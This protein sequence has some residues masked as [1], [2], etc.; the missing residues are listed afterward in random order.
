MVHIAFFNLIHFSL[1]Q[2][3]D[4][5]D[6]QHATWR[7]LAI[8]WVAM[9]AVGELL[10]IGCAGGIAVLV[11]QAI[12]EPMT[13]TQKWTVLAT[14]ICAGLMEGIITGYLQWR[15]LR[16]LWPAMTALAWMGATAAIAV[17][18]WGLGMIPSLFIFDAPAEASAAPQLPSDMIM[19]PLAALAFLVVGALFGLAQWVV[20]RH[21]ALRGAWLWIP[22][23]AVGWLVGLAVIYAAASWPDE[24]TSWYFV[25]A[26]GII[27]GF[28]GGAAVGLA[29]LWPLKRYYFQN[30]LR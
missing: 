24:S 14:M 13:M 27:G 25:V 18:G 7:R 3:F 22:A 17:F 26:L 6:V 8:H 15:V 2:Q 28:L 29:T 30:A 16:R 4:M 1:K 23:N 9:T 10:G 20:L 11:N 5:V 21:H 12:P 19:Y